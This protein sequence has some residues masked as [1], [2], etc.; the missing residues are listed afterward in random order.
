[1]N[2]TIQTSVGEALKKATAQHE[3]LKTTIDAKLQRTVSGIAAKQKEH[4]RALE[5]LASRATRQNAELPA[6]VKRI[7][8]DEL[9]QQRQALPPRATGTGRRPRELSTEPNLVDIRAAD[10]YWRARRSL[11]LYPVEGED[12]EMATRNF[13]TW[14]LGMTTVE[15]QLLPFTVKKLP[16]RAAPAPQKLVHVEFDEIEDRDKTKE[17]SQEPGRGRRRHQD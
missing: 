3:A 16:A 15:A 2:R 1:M 4:E 14:R 8:Q 13:L 6:L 12:L 9:N 10:N 11:Q 7:V 17:A 5:N